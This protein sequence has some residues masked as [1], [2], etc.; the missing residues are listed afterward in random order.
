MADNLHR[1]HAHGRNPT[2]QI[3][4]LFLIIRKAVGI[5]LFPD[6]GIAWFAFFVAVKDPFDGGTVAQFVFPGDGRDVGE[7]G[8]GIEIDDAVFLVRFE[9][10]FLRF[11]RVI[12]ID[13][14][15]FQGI[16]RDGFVVEV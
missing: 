9:A 4:H 3:N 16:G 15:A 6:G 1:R 12:G 2:Q 5:E 11:A 13:V 14:A 10:G 7:G 8:V